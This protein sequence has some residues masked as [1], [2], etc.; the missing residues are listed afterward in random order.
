MPHHLQ[1]VAVFP[2][3][4]KVRLD[5]LTR[6]GWS[7]LPADE[8][9]KAKGD[10]EAALEKSQDELVKV[11]LENERLI[12]E[13]QAHAEVSLAAIDARAQ[14]EHEL[15]TAHA[16]IKE[17][18]RERNARY[19]EGLDDG[20]ATVL[21]IN[22]PAIEEL[23]QRATAA[24]AERDKLREAICQ[25]LAESVKLEPQLRQCLR[26]AMLPSGMVEAGVAALKE[27]TDANE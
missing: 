25:V 5:S 11:R 4:S 24:E 8:L 2:S 22:G 1:F 12:D 26:E 10:S 18:E 27:P 3:G 20:K 16:R 19:Y 21:A 15:T 23:R 17:L 6:N 7:Q 9:A 13:V 14:A